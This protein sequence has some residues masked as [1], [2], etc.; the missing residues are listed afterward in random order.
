MKGKR[1]LDTSKQSDTSSAK[2]L[3][4]AVTFCRAGR[5]GVKQFFV[6]A[7]VHEGLQQT[8]FLLEQCDRAVELDLPHSV[9][10]AR[11]R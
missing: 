4:L 5:H 10:Y 11:E 6:P 8:A 1:A 9:R 3:L 2:R 7:L